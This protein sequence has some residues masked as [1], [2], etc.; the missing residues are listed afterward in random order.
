[1]ENKD[2]LTDAFKNSLVP[3]GLKFPKSIPKK[4]KNMRDYAERLK[5]KR[6]TAISRRKKLPSIKSLKRKADSLF[7]KFI[8][9]RDKKCVLCGATTELTNGHLIKR[10]VMSTRYHEE[11][12][13]CLC[14]KCN[15]KDWK[16]RSYHDRYVLWFIG[17]YGLESY[18]QITM[19]DQVLVKANRMFFESLIKKY[20]TSNTKP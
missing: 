19:M 20:G 13:N 4:K 5:N 10:G 2:V 3:I 14:S 11:N 12:C 9:A 8:I 7:S 16:F 17:K 6:L 15:F 18:S 1:M